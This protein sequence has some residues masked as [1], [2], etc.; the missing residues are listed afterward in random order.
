[1]N[2]LNQ[3]ISFFKD[4]IPISY[5]YLTTFGAV[6]LKIMVLYPQ[7]YLTDAP[8]LNM[9]EIVKNG[10]QVKNLHRSFKNRSPMFLYATSKDLVMDFKTTKNILTRDF[11]KLKIIDF[12]H[13]SAPHHLFRPEVS[14]EAALFESSFMQNL[15]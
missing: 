6:E 5:L 1:M 7:Y 9:S 12:S 10:A 8:L 4:E 11:P 15:Q 13:T 2:S 14:T 3:W